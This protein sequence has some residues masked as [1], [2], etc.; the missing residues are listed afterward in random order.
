MSRAPKVSVVIPCYNHGVFLDE[1]VASVLRQSCTDLEIVVVNDGSTDPFTVDLLK[2]YDR[3]KTRVVHTQ[4]AGLASARN[5]GI[6]NALGSYILPLD[7]DDRIAE[8]YLERAAA[9]LD[10]RPEA[11][12]V[13]C[14]QELF[15]ERQGLWDAPPYDRTAILF[16][17]LVFATALYRKSDWERVGGYSSRFVY[18]WEDW[19]FWMSMTELGKQ[20]VK[21]PEPL[22]FYRIRSSSM[23]RSM[24][25]RHKMAMMLLL[26]AR[27]RALYLEALMHEPGRVFRAGAGSFAHVLD[28]ARRG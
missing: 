4:N 3:P 19:D 1:A 15:G 26:V 28:R 24:R 7:A 22:H 16:D 8:S 20:F 12:V 21:L 9:I 27:H 5:T 6:R 13:Y 23:N 11:G 25:F 18:G 10:E 14:D 17:N 2:S